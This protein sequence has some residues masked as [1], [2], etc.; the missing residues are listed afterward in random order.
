MRP[1][2][3]VPDWICEIISPSN[4]AHDRVFKAQLYAAQHVSNLWLVDPAER[5]LESFKRVDQNWL[6]IGSYHAKS[7]ARIAPFE[8]V[9]LEVGLL[10]PPTD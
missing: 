4:A 10:F 1:I 5:I 6:L 3:I 2:S 8:E 7:V 9:E